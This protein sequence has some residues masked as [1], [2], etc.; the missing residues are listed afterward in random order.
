MDRIPEGTT[1]EQ[2]QALID[3]A[4]M[5]LLR[6]T[7]E[8]DARRIW[9]VEEEEE[10]RWIA[11]EE[12]EKRQVEEEEEQKW[13]EEE[14]RWKAADEEEARRV[15]QEQQE[16]ETDE[17]TRTQKT[18][19]KQKGKAKTRVAKQK[20]DSLLGPSKRARG[21]TMDSGDPLTT[22]AT[23]QSRPRQQA[24]WQHLTFIARSLYPIAIDHDQRTPLAYSSPPCHPPHSHY[25]FAYS[26]R[27]FLFPTP[28]VCGRLAHSSR[29]PPSLCLNIVPYRSRRLAMTPSVRYL[30]FYSSLL[31]L[32]W[33]LILPEPQAR[34]ATPHH[35]LDSAYTLFPPRV[36][37]TQFVSL[38]YS[39]F[40]PSSLTPPFSI[41]TLPAHR[42]IFPAHFLLLCYALRKYVLLLHATPFSL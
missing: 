6:L 17:E 24:D 31:L 26:S 37:I 19:R 42:Y 22:P 1:A 10:R 3:G 20:W 12:A 5:E 4:W 41:W 11:E 40:F 35:F 32:L 33:S 16:R 8:E 27:R 29:T 13:V 30:P 28:S 7:Q 9:E 25:P 39:P 34:L 36:P 21:V 2:L 23:I 14:E 15:V 38:A 18:R